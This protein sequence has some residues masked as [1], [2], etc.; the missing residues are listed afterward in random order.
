MA[1]IYV[2]VDDNNK[3]IEACPDKIEGAMLVDCTDEQKEQIMCQYD[4]QCDG[5]KITGNVSKGNNANK[6]EAMKLAKAQQQEE[7]QQ[8]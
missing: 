8:P 2:K 6:F 7:E 3:V 4:A 5:K 1:K